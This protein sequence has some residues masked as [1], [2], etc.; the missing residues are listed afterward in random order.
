MNTKQELVLLY[1][2]ENTKK[3]EQLFTLLS[4]MG[5]RMKYVNKSMYEEPIGALCEVS[6]IRI[7]GRPYQGQGFSE[8]ML[9]MKGLNSERL[10]EFLAVL[11]VGLSENVA[12]KA[13]L[14]EHNQRWS[15]LMLFQEIK[16]EHEAMNKKK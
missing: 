3:G 16:L 8:E 13:V 2:L 15:S 9:V 12:L 11:R 10:N 4:N 7:T 14:T 5:I 6:G 1:N